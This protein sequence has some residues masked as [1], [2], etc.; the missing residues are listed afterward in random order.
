[1]SDDLKPCPFCGKAARIWQDPS[2]SSAFFIGCDDGETD[3]FGGI[4][5]ETTEA[6][7]VAAWNARIMAAIDAPDLAEL[8]EAAKP[9]ALLDETDDSIGDF[10]EKHPVE[11][12]YVADLRAALTKLGVR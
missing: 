4:H 1:M 5:W 9:F 6:K 8:V 2:H 7:A 12:G 11:G 10:C 3:C